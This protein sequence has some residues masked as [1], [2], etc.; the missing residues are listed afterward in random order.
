M[1][2][3]FVLMF[4]CSK[5][6]PVQ[7]LHRNLISDIETAE[8]DV[9]A[10]QCAAENFAVAIANKEFAELEFEQGDLHRAEDHLREAQKNIS[11]A[12]EKAEECRPQD[13]DKDGI[14]DDVDECIDIP[15]SKNGYKDE[16]GCPEKDTDDDGIY[17]DMDQC[18][19]DKEDIDLF[20][21][22]DGCPDIDNDGDGILDVNEPPHCRDI[23][24]D[25]DAYQDEDG[26]PEETGDADS[27]GFPDAQDKCPNRP[28]TRNNYLDYDGCPDDIPKDV[29][30]TEG[31]IEILDKI[32]FE[33]AKAVILEQSYG[34]LHSVAQVM[35]DYPRL[36]VE[37]QG[38]TD[39][40]GSDRYNMKLSRKRAY[41]V[42]R[43]LIEKEG[44]A[45]DR[46]EAQ[47]YGERVPIADNKTPEGKEK[48]RRVEFIILEGLD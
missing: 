16:D 14:Y 24:E 2:I 22:D 18:I 41:A 45:P 3:F 28:E 33:T 15:E 7:S 37:V 19:K 32:L 20:E 12:I 34:I 5:Y 21:D 23:P 17:D 11:I 13:T 25:F 8:M 44:I 39:S 30:I 43:H 48:N 9:F 40:V 47:G 1:R 27:D 29:R 4:G 26:C 31:K 10:Q 6:G 35:R 46:L 42:R 38:H 36:R